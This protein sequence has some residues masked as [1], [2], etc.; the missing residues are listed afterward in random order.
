M[1]A[2]QRMR[3][4]WDC[5]ANVATCFRADIL[6][7]TTPKD[8]STAYAPQILP[9][10]SCH[11]HATSQFSVPVRLLASVHSFF[12]CRRTMHYSLN[13]FCTTMALV[14]CVDT[15]FVQPNIRTHKCY[16]RSCTSIASVAL[17]T[18]LDCACVEWKSLV[19]LNNT[20]GNSLGFAS[21]THV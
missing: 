14:S 18:S 3:R 15:A 9:E 4:V 21:C 11:D 12:G 16:A 5:C 10:V 8:A 1:Q 7:I 20:K 2:A 19:I 17:C 6:S 13:T